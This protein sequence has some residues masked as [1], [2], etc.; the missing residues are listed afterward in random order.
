MQLKK[1]LA[2]G[3]M[4]AMMIGST[5][6][7]A[8]SDLSK[9]PAPFVSG[10]TADTLVVV[11]K[12][13]ATDDVV[14]AVDLAARLGGAPSTSYTCKG[15]TAGTGVTG[16]GKELATTNTKVYVNDPL[17][18]TGARTTFT[19]S[20][21]P[22]TLKSGVITDSD[23]ADSYKYDQYIDF[24]AQYNV[25]FKQ[26][27]PS[28]GV[29]EDPAMVISHTD[30]TN[31][32]TPTTDNALYKARVVFQKNVNCTTAVGETV[33]L[34]GN[35]YTIASATDC[36][37]PKLVLFGSSDT[38]V[39]TAKD[40]VTVTVGGTAYTVTLGGVTGST[41]AVVT[42]GSET[43]SVTKGSTYTIGGLTVYVEDVYYYS[44]TDQ[45]SNQAKI[46]LGAQQ[47][48]F[49]SGKKVTTGSSGSEVNI[50]GTT[51]NLTRVTLSSGGYGLSALEVYVVPSTT[52]MDA[53]KQGQTFTDPVF[54]SFKIQ[55]AAST[56]AVKDASRSQLTVKNQG[57]DALVLTWTDFKGYTKDI[58]WAY[59]A[60]APQLQDSAGYN[61]H[62]TEGD[63]IA[64]NEYL[65]VDA[66]DFPHLLRVT[67]LNQDGSTDSTTD[68]I[69]FQDVFSG[70][71]YKFT[72]GTSNRTI[73]YIDGQAYYID[74]GVR[75]GVGGY[76][77]FVYITWGDGANYN[78]TG[79]VA[80]VFPKL[81]GKT[82]EYVALANKT[83][84]NL[85]V[86]RG[87]F[88]GTNISYID[89]PQ[90]RLAVTIFNSGG[91]TVLNLTAY[92]GYSVGT[93]NTSYI[94]LNGTVDSRAVYVGKTS[95]GGFYYNVSAG[96]S[97]AT[98]PS[99]DATYVNNTP[100]ILWIEPLGKTTTPKAESLPS[101]TESYNNLIFVEEQEKSGDVYSIRV[102]AI[103]ASSGGTT[104][105]GASSP[106][107]TWTQTPAA[108]GAALKTDTY[109]TQFIDLYG[110]FAEKYAYGVDNTLKIWYPDDQMTNDIYVLG[111][112]GVVTTTASTAGE[113]IQQAVPIK[114]AI[115]KLDTEV[116]D[117][118]KQTKNIIL[119]GGPCVNTLV[120]TLAT[121]GKF[122]YTCSNW[123]GENFALIRL[124]DDAFTTGKTALV[125]AGTRAADTRSATTALQ[126]YDVSPYSG[127]LTGTKV[128]VVDTT[129]TTAA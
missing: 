68:A 57:N 94:R 95:T 23:A 61:I 63:R 78:N 59:P 82:G 2:A 36:S 81:K 75:T 89:L 119:V 6:A 83:A 55:Y 18:K 43:K 112:D 73:A 40:P 110:A 50:D 99:L 13:A 121:G 70:S 120:A 53:I 76:T 58:T 108:T 31:P 29:T 90:G 33:N 47:L 34:F 15:A 14:G 38:R 96:N 51:A 60:L 8:A 103:N 32:T 100:A 125:I 54:K 118:D 79:S 92:T 39:F 74:G 7:I 19:S 126:Q 66:G 21:L 107:Y 109:T 102:A 48:T 41:T 97:T 20:E 122:D 64:L 72:L 67:T 62:A 114:T 116:S 115:A 104:R 88:T 35:T 37:T 24:T 28:N 117:A 111:P 124:V 106:D 69:E 65:V 128:K 84:L 113:T 91:V 30:G 105:I 26:Y 44:T 16:E 27:I 98:M 129:V 46:G 123:P 22:T 45:S 4:G 101:A 80:T 86:S 10:S 49:E 93:S 17:K 87:V 25:T 71:T 127:K 12:T 77:N 85:S 11:G 42:V 5:V 9:Y 52:T 3:A 56:P 1:I